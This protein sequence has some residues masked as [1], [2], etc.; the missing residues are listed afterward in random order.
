MIR[1]LLLG[2]F[3]PMTCF[4]QGTMLFTWH[5]VSNYFQASFEITAAESQPGVRWTSD[6]FLD[7]M[8]V[9]YPGQRIMAAIPLAPGLAGC[10]WTLPMH[11]G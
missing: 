4:G 7:S 5:G 6:L 11:G 2:F 3:L 1:I 10:T 8:S 9:A